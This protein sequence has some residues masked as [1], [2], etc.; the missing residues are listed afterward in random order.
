MSET[1]AP[2]SYTQESL[3]LIEQLSGR[4][5]PVYNESLA[6]TINGALD[7][8]RLRDAFCRVVARHE[9][10]RTVFT[11]TPDGLRAVVRDD[12]P[13]PDAV[14]EL[15]DLTGAS[16][17]D[18]ARR[19]AAQAVHDAYQ[20]PFDLARGP[21]VRGLIARVTPQETLFGL[22]AHHIVV[23]GWSLGLLLEEISHQYA[24]GHEPQ[25]SA[26]PAPSYT[27]YARRQRQ[28]FAQ[29]DYD[30][31]I[32]TLRESL[33]GQPQL[34]KVPTDR[35]RPAEQ[36]YRGATRR[37]VV[38]RHTLQPLF[39]RCADACDSTEFAVLMAV[40][41]L[42]MSRLSDQQEVTIG[43]TVLNRPEM[44]DLSTVGC[45]VN[46]VAVPFS[47]EPGLS[48]RQLVTRTADSLLDLLELQESPYPK[49]LDAL[50]VSRDPSHNPVFQTMLTLLG[51]R[52][53]LRLD[54][55]LTVRP[56]HLERVAS[57]FDLMLYVTQDRD[58]LEI[59]AEFNTDLF[60]PSSI[61]RYLRRF[62]HTAKN[63][64]DLEIEV[65]Q[66]GLLPDDER[67]V[68]LRQWND[69]ATQYEG[70]T[71]IDAIEDQ[72]ARTPDAVAVEFGDERLTYAELDAA[73]ERVA[74]SL[75]RLTNDRAGGDGASA[76]FVGVFMERSLDMVVA[77]LSIVKAGLAYV[78]I[79]PDY[80][81]DR[82][83][84][85]IED[86]AAP[87]ILTQNKFR[88][89]LDSIGATS[90]TLGELT[91]ATEP[92]DR[93]VRPPLL[94]DDRVYMIYTSGSTGRPKGVINRHVS[95][96]NRLSWMQEQYPLTLDDRVLQKTPFSFD[97]S[98]WEFFWPLMTGARIVVA[99]P[100][101]HRDPQYLAELIAERR[102]TTLHFVPSMLTLFLE[103]ED[104]LRR[105]CGSLRRV[106][107]SGEALPHTSVAAFTA[108]LDCELH[109]LY[110]PTE[111]AIDVSH[112]TADPQYPGR[113]VPIGK[114]IAN[115]HLYVV[116]ERLRLQPVGVP[117]E[118]C[119]GGVNLAEGYHNRPDLTSR[120]F[121]EGPFDDVP[122]QRLYRTGDLARFLPDGNIEYL[123]RIDNQ[124]KL[125]GLRIELG[126]I[127]AVLRQLPSVRG[128][129]V[130]LHEK[131]G[132][133]ALVAYVVASNF[134]SQQAVK[135]LKEQLP[136]FMVPQRYIEIPEIPL[137][138]NGKLDRKALPD[139]GLIPG[140]MEAPASAEDSDRPST[141]LQRAVAAVWA[142][143]LEIEDFGVDANF[144]QLGG[145]SIQGIR[146]ASGLRAAG[147]RIAVKDIFAHPTVRTLASHLDATSG[148]DSQDDD[149]EAATNAR[150]P[151]CTLTS[152]DRATLPPEAQDA[153]PL[154]R[155]QAGMVYHSML[156]EGSS[157]Y[158]DIFSYDIQATLRP[159]TL[160]SAVTAV[161]AR[162]GQLRSN[163]DL[164]GYSQ[165]L[166][167]VLSTLVP[168]IEIADLD[169]LPPA[170]QASQLAAWMEQEKTRDFD[171]ETGPLVRFRATRR[172][173]DRFTLTISFH[174]AVLDGWSVS[175]VIE[176]IRSAYAGLLEQGQTAEAAAPD[177]LPYSAYVLLEQKALAN[178]AHRAF[179]SRTLAGHTPVLLCGTTPAAHI[180]RSLSQSRV[181]PE[182]HATTMRRTAD[183]LGVPVKSGYL[184][185]HLHT[186]ARLAGRDDAL[187]GLVVNGRP[188][189]EG[190]EQTVGL[191]LNTLPVAGRS[192]AEDWASAFRSAFAA[193]QA[194]LSHRRYPLSEIIR[195][196]REDG[197]AGELFD[198]VFNFTD[199]HVYGTTDAAGTH[200]PAASITGAS[201]FEQTNFPFVVHAARDPFTRAMTL[202][203]NYDS[204]AVPDAVVTRYLDTFLEAAQHTA[205][206]VASPS[207]ESAGA[208]PRLVDDICSVVGEALRLERVDEQEEFT[209]LGM[210]SISAIRVVAKIRRLGARV[211]LSDL[212]AYPSAS[213]LAAHLEGVVPGD[214][215]PGGPARTEPFGLAGRPRTDFPA[216]IVDAYPV[217]AI[218]TVMIRRFE[219]DPGQAVY[220]D[221][222]GYRFGLR[223]DSE[224]LRTSLQHLID[225]HDTL[226]TAF[227]L[228]ARPEP[229]QLVHAQ[230]E[231]DVRVVDLSEQDAAERQASYDA[232]F[233]A[234]KETGFEW[235][236]PP[237]MRFTA[238]RFT[239]D[240]F[241]LTLSFHHAI[242]DGWS[243]SLLIREFVDLYTAALSQESENGVRPPTLPYR[244]F[245]AQERADRASTEAR[246]FWSGYLDGVTYEPLPI[247]PPTG[248]GQPARWSEAKLTVA[249]ATHEALQRLAQ[250]KGVPLK[251]VLLAVHLGVLGELH[252][253]N[254]VTT[255]VFT[256]GRLEDDGGD[257]TLGMFLNFIPVRANITGQG[258]PAL[259]AEAFA[260]E[261]RA[262]A[263]RRYPLPDIEHDLGVKH[264][265]PTAFNYT[266]FDSYADVARHG[267][268]RGVQW[269]EHT[270][271]TVL[272][273]VGHDIHQE[274][275]VLTLNAD[276][277]Q[278]GEEDLI[279]L[280]ERY[281]AVLDHI[282]KAETE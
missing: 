15:L 199:F 122:D 168:H 209:R 74:R 262:L 103:Q 108:V 272:A 273:N 253:Q 188:E 184:A 56:H 120:A 154:T 128:A 113:V 91:S 239:A 127:E 5:E 66:V 149:A 28:A 99:E 10:L 104:E 78:P 193:E 207:A 225:R 16:D 213:A 4:A 234:E 96:H 219:A 81:V 143:V 263:H 12:A 275:I 20:R 224:A 238:H 70:T 268:L 266:Q 38:P 51:E 71:V 107:C 46:T 180:P 118:L 101:G 221:V 112:W 123:G 172:S 92:S 242:I 218:Q 68:I 190:G 198:T 174:H 250:R 247:T 230:V 186:L 65:D 35:P 132:A 243:L 86:S 98:V 211:S 1:L 171:L 11:E 21:L 280:A 175:L 6:F 130:I 139:P 201:Y 206:P 111:A 279:H 269:F 64:V 105:T 203:V 210:D 121:V 54:S 261:R 83:R 135:A 106:F 163:V 177:P 100:G 195:N 76:R 48:F 267:A 94:P 216:R 126:E 208:T 72:V 138:A 67:D 248:P 222:F 233:E 254:A 116:D 39:D 25:P 148:G 44:R 256:G 271:F 281:R 95:L 36:T 27:A 40:H 8:G 220:H 226:R 84:Y 282:A 229:L 240:E 258:W 49:V 187:T 30:E 151:F 41:A 152:S 75:G 85:M 200:T 161:A 227:D 170:E 119:I 215:G 73:A 129:A 142:G 260:H 204:A 245:V 173:Q 162:H 277:R 97:V 167:I 114:P 265:A 62:V 158:H 212:Y 205:T 236:R 82:I 176:Q 45:F 93:P 17:V 144:F 124:V 169:G 178:P 264:I 29:G 47:F 181:V 189:A 146:I 196:A 274:R 110:G 133:Q 136:E 217:T 23:D 160:R 257:E 22:T 31:Q 14:V 276:G 159:E 117:G 147:H 228:D 150:I 140:A 37:L 241:V 19:R 77:L 246:R 131:P 137:S 164:A 249:T 244:H 52:K 79:D 80:P 141:G 109:N 59:E 252:G 185:V 90:T 214:D 182:T 63:I 235:L 18:A 134:D 278:I 33:E 53:E 57:K 32:A 43:T 34:L 88:P 237:L 42:L 165:P 202:T 69:T 26:D 179:W 183:E 55:G 155:L 166:Q 50:N 194:A 156:H 157:V 231:A 102:V 192:A 232:W 153:W 270:Q 251:H 255:H 9:A 58:D 223:F 61:E 191:F 259:A 13:A 145:D 87:L 197:I 24:E 60:D 115:T 3:W 2:L 125:H 7:V 89:T